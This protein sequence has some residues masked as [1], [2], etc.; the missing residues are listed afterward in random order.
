[1]LPQQEICDLPVMLCTERLV[2]SDCF[3]VASFNTPK[4]LIFSQCFFSSSV[5]VLVATGT[6]ADWQQETRWLNLECLIRGLVPLPQDVVH[7]LEIWDLLYNCNHSNRIKE[8]NVIRESWQEC[9]ES[10][11]RLN[12]SS[13]VFMESPLK[14]SLPSRLHLFT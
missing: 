5:P 4:E 2:C 12:T 11:I 9:G 10:L 1:M 8:Q 6:A 7:T 3:Q 13:N 14:Y